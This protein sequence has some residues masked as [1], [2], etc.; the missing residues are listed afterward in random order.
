M[1]QGEAIV[2]NI[3]KTLVSQFNESNN[4]TVKGEQKHRQGFC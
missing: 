4:R 2:L 3:S 1:Y